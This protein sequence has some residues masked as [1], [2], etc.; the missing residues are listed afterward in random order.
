ML[1]KKVDIKLLQHTPQETIIITDEEL[2]ETTNVKT[3]TYMEGK[4]RRKRDGGKKSIKGERSAKRQKPS[5]E[6]T[7][8]PGLRY[9]GPLPN[10][11]YVN[12][13]D[14]E[15]ILSGAGTAKTWIEFVANIGENNL[16]KFPIREQQKNDC[17]VCA[18][19]TAY[20]VQN[21]AKFPKEIA[22]LGDFKRT[23][24]EGAHLIDQIPRVWGKSN[25]EQPQD[26]MKF[27]KVLKLNDLVEHV[28]MGPVYLGVTELGYPWAN[29]AS[30]DKYGRKE[31]F[32]PPR[33]DPYN[34]PWEYKRR[35]GADGH[36]V[37]IIGMFHSLD[38]FGDGV[39][40]GYPKRKSNKFGNVFVTKCTCLPCGW[41]FR[42]PWSKTINNVPY[43]REEISYALLPADL[44][45]STIRDGGVE[46]RAINDGYAMTM[47][48]TALEKLKLL[49]SSSSSHQKD[50]TKRVV[51]D[52]T[53]DSD[54]HAIDVIDN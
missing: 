40:N 45:T 28:K 14:D 49:P 31:K 36:A 1:N 13:M 25:L 44:F 30:K 19:V 54:M 27:R 7:L 16:R 12:W 24:N 41:S 50:E 47:A 21:R 29:R 4:K 22:A 17:T 46:R 42:P 32:I 10:F 51:V 35:S 26:M 33:F 43:G 2:E 15:Y 48:N 23:K 11:Q 52:L 38:L 5:S 18:A 9:R 53:D 8:R 34:N 37:V 6:V 20:E 39:S 3:S